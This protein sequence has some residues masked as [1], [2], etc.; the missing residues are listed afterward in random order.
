MTKA[1]KIA[2]F[3][4]EMLLSV[5]FLT[6]TIMFTV[7]SIHN[8]KMNDDIKA[9]IDSATFEFQEGNT[10]Y[11]VVETTGLDTP[12]ID[13]EKAYAPLLGATGD[14]FLMPQSRM[15]YFPFFAEFVSYLFGGHAG[16]V[17]DDG[18]RL[19]EAMGG[20]P[21]ESHVYN[22]ST[23]LYTEERMV[24]GLRVKASKEER[25]Q[26]ANNAQALVGKNYN[27]LFVLNTEDNY[28]CT[29]VCSRVYG[30]E[31]GM[32]YNIDTNGFHVSLQDLYRSE[33]TYI[34]FVKYKVGNETHIYYLKNK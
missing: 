4:I 32:N 29:D 25:E 18:K 34:T 14:I 3:T 15:S 31:F 24:V 27:Y 30:K 7:A 2:L 11:Y 33:D 28:Y 9:F 10:Y 8:I 5:V 13:N 16:I 20:S 19:V 23:D 1:Y 22:Y 6:L 17:I 21:G 26:A 12:T